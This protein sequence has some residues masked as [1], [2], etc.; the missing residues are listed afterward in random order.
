MS[1][2]TNSRY[3]SGGI[4]ESESQ[5]LQKETDNFTKKYEHERKRYM[6]LED[7]YKQ[8][9]KENKE[10][11]VSPDILSGTAVKKQKA[12]IRVLENQLE[13]SV[14]QY[15]SVMSKNKTQQQQVDVMRKELKTT[16]K[17]LKGL[18][19][20]MMKL[21]K[22]IKKVNED[23]AT[24]QKDTEETNNQILALKAKHENDK[25]KFEEKMQDLQK[26]LDETDTSSKR[27]KRSM[28]M[29]DTP[30][31]ME[32]SGTQGEEFSNPADL[33]KQRLLKWQQNNKEKKQLMDKYI[34]NVKIIEDAFEHIKEQ[35]GIA[36]TEEIVTTFIKAE[37]QNYSL[38]NYVNKLNS[39][40][41]TIEEQNKA[42]KKEI[43][44]LEEK[45]EQN[46]EQKDHEVKR[47]KDEI[48]ISKFNLENEIESKTKDTLVAIQPDVERMVKMFSSSALPLS[49][50]QP[51]QY[52]ED[53]QLNDKNATQYLAELEEYIALLITHV[54]MKQDQPNAVI[55]AIPL[56]K[57]DNKTFDKKGKMIINMK[58]DDKFSLDQEDEVDGQIDNLAITGKDLYK[59]FQEKREKL[60]YSS[61]IDPSNA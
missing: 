16:N 45:R 32:S 56:E 20:D 17:V 2:T 60:G 35:T 59:R 28:M 27:M 39:D 6:I 25:N 23:N 30:S 11:T 52:D 38:Y 9:L 42:I 13:K 47:I 43:Q 24:M 41:D 51:M 29:E 10:E 5:R 48:E 8:A 34:R 26:K 44:F 21:T 18:D 55:Q 7:Q 4:Y 49:V 1:E 46:D 33:L 57:L 53:T 3:M 61:V 12:K 54:A 58:E 50:A 14:T 31:K 22:K 40:I 15:N 19:R 37:E 36:T